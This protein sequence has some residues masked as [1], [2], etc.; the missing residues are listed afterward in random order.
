MLRLHMRTKHRGT[1][2]QKEV[3]G[4]DKIVIENRDEKRKKEKTNK[5]IRKRI[6]CQQ[7]EKKFNKESRYIDH[8]KTVH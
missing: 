4:G 3:T 2:N 1:V 7:C 5:Y 8:M 6:E